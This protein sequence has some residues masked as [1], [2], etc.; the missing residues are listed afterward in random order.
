MICAVLCVTMHRYIYIYI[1]YIYI[2]ITATNN[3]YNSTNSFSN[4]D[5][6]SCHAWNHLPACRT[7]AGHCSARLGFLYLTNPF[8]DNQPSLGSSTVDEGSP[9]RTSREHWMVCACAFQGPVL[10]GFKNGKKTKPGTPV[11]FVVS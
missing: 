7:P 1:V 8:G 11:F 10:C 2:Y 5:P 9:S 4:R 3:G 6:H